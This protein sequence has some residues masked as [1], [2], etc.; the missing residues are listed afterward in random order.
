[1]NHV[2]IFNAKNSDK[3]F[4][5]SPYDD[6]TFIFKTFEL[7]ESLY[8]IQ[9]FNILVSNWALNIPISRLAEP[10]RTY[11]RKENLEKYYSN[12]INY[13][14]LD[15]DKVRTKDA[16]DRILDYFSTYKCI[17]GESKSYNE[18]NNFNMKGI[19]YIEPIKL[20]DAKQAISN[21]NFDLKDYCDVDEAVARRVT[22]NAPI[23]KNKILLNRDKELYHCKFEKRINKVEDGYIEVE[24]KKT[25]IDIND[26]TGDTPEEFCINVFK[27]MGFEPIDSKEN[28]SITFKHPSE[29]KSIGGYFWF[30]KSPFTMHH[31]NSTR[32]INIY[33]AVKKSPI[34]KELLKED[35]DYNDKFLQFNTA[36]EL[37]TCHE[38]YLTVAGK[39]EQIKQ[40]LEE[41]DG[42]FSIKSPMGT[43]KST[44]IKYIIDEAHDIDMRVLIITNRISVAKDFAKKYQ[45]KI[46]N[47]DQY[48]FGDSMI[49]QFDSLWKYDM[50]NFDIVVMDEFISLIGHS[51]SKL[52]NSSLNI[53]KFF[54]AFNKKL[55]I[56]DAFLT[57]YENFLLEHKKTNVYQLNNT[58]RDKTTL[59]SYECKNHFIQQVL[60]HA[61]QH[62]IT[63]SGISTT[64]L[65]STKALLEK[66]GLKVVL[67]NASTPESTKELIY[68][69]FEESEHDKWDVCMYSPTLTVGVSN[70]NNVHH[71]FHYDSAMA[72]DVISSIQMIKRT[73]KAKEIHMFISDRMN[74]VKT[75][76]NA[77]RD[78]Y[79]HNVGKNV[80]QN[81]LFDVDDY[82]E[83][84]LSK[85]GKNVIKIDTFKNILEFNHKKAMMWMMKYHFFHEPRIVTHKFEGNILIKYNK[86]IKDNA[87]AEQDNVIKDFLA[88]NNY[89]KMDILM[90]NEKS[91]AS[92]IKTLIE[93][94]E[95]IRHDVNYTIKTEILKISLK[96][97]RFI[98][99]CQN[100][101][102]LKDYT[103]KF[104]DNAYIKSKIS[105]NIIQHMDVK[106][107]NA[108]MRY[109]QH[110]IQL[111]YI[112]TPDKLLMYILTEC[113]FKKGTKELIAHKDIE[114]MAESEKMDYLEKTQKV[115]RIDPKV[116]E[117]Y[118]YIRD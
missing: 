34:G 87:H 100:Y 42:L 20:I 27:S 36:T 76:Y 2:T 40:F 18:T 29:V 55:V 46:Y 38:P 102:L 21:L 89:E 114:L 17:I 64:F 60:A 62:K 56:A 81:F 44:I 70:L 117:Y 77:I 78:E 63:I 32:S 79:I 99:K 26:I 5:W 98:E 22:F 47:K 103:A 33:D 73:R 31:N 93:L 96:D 107:Y 104:V 84:R 58:W 51:R 4:A 80:D 69:L 15:L 54:G 53:A 9:M 50:K 1:L 101:K 28:G 41:K 66:H 105:A 25:N 43:A 90:S 85:I 67:L 16:R 23:G 7:E 49:V 92:T 52:Q 106:F 72:S 83:A 110:P 74:F 97:S 82:G 61:K 45:M 37:I 35:L 11:R 24:K 108:L 109:G 19:L 94:E 111:F 95:N 3:K 10:I 39:E 86:E 91:T 88:L 30:R 115:L 8:N 75:T 65:L 118:G 12:E 71:H 112:G 113:G 68:E 6:K 59:F 57:G 14:I 48:N 13:F 116:K